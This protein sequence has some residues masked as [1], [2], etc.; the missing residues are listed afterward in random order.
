[1]RKAVATALVAASSFLLGY[2]V[3]T[4]AENV[5]CREQGPERNDR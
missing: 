4:V 2:W 3:G 1:M 5:A